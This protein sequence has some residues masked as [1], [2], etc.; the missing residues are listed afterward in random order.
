MQACT[1]ASKKAISLW[2]NAIVFGGTIVLLVN[3]ILSFDR[4]EKGLDEL[5]RWIMALK[6]W[7]LNH[8]LNQQSLYSS[9]FVW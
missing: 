5:G 7:L 1:W 3:N 4:G 6:Q 8:H 9:I 2:S